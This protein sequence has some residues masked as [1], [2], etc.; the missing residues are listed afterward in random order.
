MSW[1]HF[2]GKLSVDNRTYFLEYR[3]RPRQFVFPVCGSHALCL[4]NN[5]YYKQENQ[6]VC[7]TCR[8]VSTRNLHIKSFSDQRLEGGRELFKE[9]WNKGCLEPLGKPRG[10]NSLI[11]NHPDNNIIDK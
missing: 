5:K 1:W 4:G 11:C 8:A 3:P 6:L 7:T 2:L 9:E 10:N